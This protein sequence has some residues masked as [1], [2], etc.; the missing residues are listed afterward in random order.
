MSP[1]VGCDLTAQG[2][3]VIH[4]GSRN[5]FSLVAQAATLGNFFNLHKCKIAAARYVNMCY[6]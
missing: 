6:I 3:K 2:N 5:T 1:G 4:R